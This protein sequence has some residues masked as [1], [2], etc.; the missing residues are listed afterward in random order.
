[1]SIMKNPVLYTIYE[2]DTK[3]F[4]SMFCENKSRPQLKCNG[5]C[6]LAKMQKEQEDNDASNRLKQL[7][8]EVVYFNVVTPVYIVSDKLLFVEEVKPPAYYNQL[9]SFL[10]TSHLVKPPDTSAL[11]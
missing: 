7:Q 5:K 3:L 6:Y 4:V 8:T 9:Y 10:F 11:S 1:M 2:Y